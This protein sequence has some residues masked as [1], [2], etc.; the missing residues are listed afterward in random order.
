MG[1]EMAAKSSD[2]ALISTPDS[3]FYLTGLDHW[4]DFAPHLLIVPADDEHPQ[5]KIVIAHKPAQVDARC[6]REGDQNQRDVGLENSALLSICGD[7]RSRTV[8]LTSSPNSAKSIR[9]VS[10]ES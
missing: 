3:I 1:S 2:V 5:R 8:E 6:V 10:T 7:M 4:S 9:P